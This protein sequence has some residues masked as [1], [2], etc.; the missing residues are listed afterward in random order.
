MNV[1]TAGVKDELGSFT[2]SFTTEAHMEAHAT[3][4]LHI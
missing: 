1:V 2:G 3:L 4:L